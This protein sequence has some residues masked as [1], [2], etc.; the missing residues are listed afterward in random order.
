[1]AKNGHH[2]PQIYQPRVVLRGISPLIWRRLLVR[3]DSTVA[4]LHQALQVAFGWDDEQLNRF[5]IR[6][7]EYAVYRDGGGMIG[8]DATGVRLGDLDLRR[9]E[10]FVY[11][12]D[13]GDSWIHDLR[14]EAKLPV[15]PR[16]TYPVCVAG[17]CSAP[18]EDCGGPSAFM[19]NRQYYAGV[20]RGPSAEDLDDFA[21]E[22][23][24]EESDRSGDYDPN[25]FDRR[26]IN[27]ALGKLAAGSYEEALDEIHNPGVD[28]IPRRADTQRPG[29]DD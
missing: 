24:D 1:M 27:R 22:F 11:E 15:D 23:D 18:P 9:L 29:P 3:S 21:D 12:Y 20:G 2:D 19:A 13:F 16:K 5:E 6:G 8:I 10:R 7:R 26:Q 14:L 17:K 25:R 28:R 4:Q